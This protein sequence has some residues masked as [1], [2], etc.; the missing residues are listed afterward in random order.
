MSGSVEN[1]EEVTSSANQQSNTRPA[2]ET[3]VAASSDSS[4]KPIP[5]RAPKH[6]GP[7]TKATCNR[8]RWPTEDR[9]GCYDLSIAHL[10]YMRWNSLYSIVPAI[11]AVIGI[12]ATLFVV[13]VYIMYNET[14]VVKASGRE[15]SYLLLISMIMC[16]AMTFVLLSKPNAATMSARR[17]LFIS[18]LSQVVL[19]SMLAGVQLISSLIWLLVVPPGS[20]HN[21]P[22][23]DQVV[24]TCNVPDHHFLYSLAYDGILIIACTVYAVK[25]RKVPENFNETKFIGF[26]MYTTCV[27]WLSWIFF[28]FGTGSDFQVQIQTTSLCISISMSAN[29]A[30]VCIFSPKLWIILFEKHK[31]VRKQDGDM[32][33]KRRVIFEHL[34]ERIKENLSETA[35]LVFM[36]PQ[37]KNRINTQHCFPVIGIL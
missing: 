37:P 21:Y 8:K 11:F 26:S 15:L 13:G 17:P 9:K 4:K 35:P 30:L 14:P 18:P 2:T 28:F 19:T 32:L 6:V 1:E 20:R 12:I 16:Y 5:Q 7:T 22:S 10:R 29:V 31:N 33:N 3:S 36:D 25:T 34:V 27:V 23:R 24:L